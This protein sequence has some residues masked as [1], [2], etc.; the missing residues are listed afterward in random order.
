MGEDG[1]QGA[2]NIRS[3][4]GVVIAQDQNTSTIY[5]MPKA[6]VSRNAADFVLPLADIPPKIVELI[7]SSANG[8]G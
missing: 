1:A 8:P 2:V 3:A 6:V 7:K 4:G 5:G